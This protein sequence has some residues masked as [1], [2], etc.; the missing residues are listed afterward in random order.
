MHI[1]RLE[2][3]DATVLARFLYD[4]AFWDEAVERPPPEEVL[5]PEFARYI[6]AWGRT[7]DA[8]V[9]AED[10]RAIGAAWYRLFTQDEPGYGF[11]AADIP[12]LSIAVD[13]Q[14]RGRGVGAA[15]LRELIGMAADEG[16]AAL[17]LSVNM[18]NPAKR[19]YERLGFRG[20]R[21]AHGN[22]TMILRNLR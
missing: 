14:W 16:Y 19:L 17:S 12:E 5:G 9:I 22:V 18:R 6:E 13:E 11:V 3:S 1:R 8:G 2:A 7:G 4:A 15:L 10:D 20:M 21:G